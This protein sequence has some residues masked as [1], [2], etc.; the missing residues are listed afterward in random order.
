[1]A[2]ETDDAEDTKEL[3][4]FLQMEGDRTQTGRKTAA[5]GHAVP[6][7]AVNIDKTVAADCETDTGV[8]EGLHAC[9]DCAET[10]GVHR[11]PQDY[12]RD[13]GKMCAI[14]G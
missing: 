5:I 4:A 3:A 7:I 12:G 14:L 8:Q 6:Q 11:T 13:Q 1:M 2:H 9:Q 10:Q